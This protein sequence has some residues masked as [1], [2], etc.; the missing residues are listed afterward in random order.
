VDLTEP[1]RSDLPFG[2]RVSGMTREMLAR[3]GV[4]REM[5]ALLEE[6]GLIV[7][8]DIEP[9]SEM[10]LALS[11]VF[12][13]L[14]EIP[15]S[16]VARTDDLPPGVI[17]IRHDPE[18]AGIVEIDG[19][20]L[21]HWLPWHFDHCHSD[22]LWRAAVLRPLRIPPQGGLTGFADGIQMY[23]ALS[24]ELRER[25][26]GLNVIYTLDVLFEHMRFG[27]PNGFRE[28]RVAP[29]NMLSTAAARELP[30]AIH[31]A[32]WTRASGEDVLH[33]SPWMAVGIEHHEDQAGD[34]LLEELCREM[35]SSATPYFHA[36]KPTDMLVWDNWRMLHSATGSDPA[37]PRRMH[38]ATILGDY[39]LGYFENAAR[40]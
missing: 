10:Q 3:D 15:A 35:I 11:K 5:R 23:G 36:W 26:R 25:V 40:R 13:E 4:R 22:R 18:D 31:P 17:D 9:S 29:S 30:R 1:L 27:R 37:Q 32:V 7:F 16:I 21:S 19:R 39:G 20:R 28:I 12:G 38:R 8:E 6:R 33:V 34:A 14:E 24:R 2:A